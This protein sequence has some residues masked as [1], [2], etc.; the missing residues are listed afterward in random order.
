MEIEDIDFES[1]TFAD[2]MA[3]DDRYNPRAYAL[4][5]HVIHVL[6]AGGRH[7]AGCEMIEEFRE[8]ALD[9]YGPMAYCV[10]KEWG[11]TRCEDLGEMTHNLVE[12]GRIGKDDDDPPETFAGAYD[13]E[14]AFL[15]PYEP[16]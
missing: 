7:F 11:L 1:D 16:L 4:L 15:E 6:S 3:K 2:I 5:A 9:Q 8:T 13:F 10:L 14:E 12:S